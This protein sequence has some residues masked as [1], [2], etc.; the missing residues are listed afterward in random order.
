M[1]NFQV[2]TLLEQAKKQA[3]ETGILDSS[4]LKKTEDILSLA[5]E[6]D[7]AH[8]EEKAEKAQILETLLAKAAE[9]SPDEKKRITSYFNLR[10]I[11]LN[12]AR[13]YEAEKKLPKPED[14]IRE[15]IITTIQKAKNPAE[16][17]KA[18]IE[19][20]NAAYVSHTNT[21]HPQVFHSKPAVEF[22]RAISHRLAKIAKQESGNEPTDATVN[23][24]LEKI[25]DGIGNFAMEG[26]I[27]HIKQITTDEERQNELDNLKYITPWQTETLEAWNNVI[28]EIAT[29]QIPLFSAYSRHLKLS[30]RT[31]SVVSEYANQL[32]FSPEEKQKVFYNRS[33]NVGKGDGDGREEATAAGMQRDIDMLIDASGKYTGPIIDMRQNSEVHSNFIC[34]IVQAL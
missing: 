32:K 2:E 31:A 14:M 6:Y 33:W 30:Q 17:L 27:T 8:R 3:L 15:F 9:L 18:L 29:G 16:A 21:A 12:A 5:R 13:N 4:M 22:E 24:L 25:N 7:A 23:R 20:K 10:D 11:M 28:E 19:S 1:V 26:N 34:V